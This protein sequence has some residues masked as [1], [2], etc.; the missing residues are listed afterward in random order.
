MCS[1]NLDLSTFSEQLLTKSNVD[2]ILYF[3]S[4]LFVVR[5]FCFTSAVRMF[6][7][8]NDERFAN[9]KAYLQTLSEVKHP[10]V[11][12]S[13]SFDDV[14][15]YDLV[16]VVI[17][18]SRERALT[19]EDRL[20]TYNLGYLTQT[21]A[22]LQQIVHTDDTN[23]FQHKKLVVCSVD[24]LP[25]RFTEAWQLSRF[26]QTVFRYK[27]NSAKSYDVITGNMFEREKDD[28]I[29]CLR[30]AS[31]FHSPYYLVLEDD[32]L[33]A[34]NAVG[35]LSFLMN[36][37][38]LFSA[39]DWL[40][41]KLYYPE[42]WS[43]YSLSWQTVVELDGYAVMGGSLCASAVVMLPMSKRRKW[44]MVPLLFWFVVGA[45]FTALLCLSIGRQYVEL[46]RQY[47]VS[48]HRVVAAPGCCTQ[49]TLYPAHVVSDL[50]SH[51]SRV[52]CDYDFSVDIA[53]D[54]FARVRGLK[55]YLVQ[56]NI[57][58]HIGLISN[59]RRNSKSA[60]HFL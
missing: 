12:N 20:L 16:I 49:A 18:M 50:C 48:T 59:L 35:T 7:Q 30:T 28:Y 2:D 38:N 11:S 42:K 51:L 14:E 46:W 40:F 32:V 58:K 26:V 33:L 5:N 52:P 54:G 47:L 34:E 25:Q 13:D 60:R 57:G 37:C 10:D 3:I 41:L 15:R 43:G 53:I 45:V 24:P 17:T 23:A 21:V 19:D 44:Q 4:F 56:P 6:L 1:F 27:N 55:T 29:F 36:Y 39:I 22:R 9:A 31:Q 8:A